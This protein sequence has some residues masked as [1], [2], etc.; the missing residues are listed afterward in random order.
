[1]RHY[2]I[3]KV[4]K[5]ERSE[6]SNSW[7]ITE[8]IN[9]ETR[10]EFNWVLSLNE[11]EHF[12]AYAYLGF[13]DCAKYPT[14]TL[15]FA[16]NQLFPDDDIDRE[17]KFELKPIVPNIWLVKKE[18]EQE[19][20][21]NLEPYPLG[22]KLIKWLNN[23]YNEISKHVIFYD[24]DTGLYIS[25][26]NEV[27]T[28]RPNGFLIPKSNIMIDST[29]SEEPGY[30][31]FLELYMVHDNR[32]PD[33]DSMGQIYYRLNGTNRGANADRLDKL[34]SS[35]PAIVEKTSRRQEDIGS[36]DEQ[37]DLSDVHRLVDPYD[38]MEYAEV[39]ITQA[40]IDNIRL[41]KDKFPG[42]YV[43]V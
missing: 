7:E 33:P 37:I 4:L 8:H 2:T 19:H 40:I 24:D 30:S 28:G 18:P 38:Y 29:Y 16:H 35:H 1:M 20:N 27:Q 13:Y 31:P 26:L 12:I 10:P 25:D 3:Q 11:L 43:E 6:Q 39:P 32:E 5:W 42:L 41:Y 34:L 15:S 36:D 21:Q 23:K 14:S 22:T 17:Y 9:P